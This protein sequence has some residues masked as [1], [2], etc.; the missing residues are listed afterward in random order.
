MPDAPKC[1]GRKMKR[2]GTK[3]VCSRCHG[4]LDSGVTRNV[5]TLT[6]AGRWSA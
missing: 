1:C 5:T 3:F 2:E 6:L 4:W